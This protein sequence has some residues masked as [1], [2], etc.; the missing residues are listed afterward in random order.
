MKKILLNQNGNQSGPYT[1]KEVRQKIWSGDLSTEDLGWYEGCSRWFS[2][3]EILKANQTQVSLKTKP[4]STYWQST[5]IMIAVVAGIFFVITVFAAFSHME[6]KPKTA[7]NYYCNAC[8]T[9]KEH[10]IAPAAATFAPFGK[11]GGAW[12]I[13]GSYWEAEG[14]VDAANAYGVKLRKNWK[15][16]WNSQ[17]GEVVYYSFDGVSVIGTEEQ[18]KKIALGGK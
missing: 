2:I 18:A 14:W 4:Q 16:A 6:D 9:V 5:G 1:L 13:G 17:G 7:E 8:E 15:M 3:G 12:N 11:N 10:L